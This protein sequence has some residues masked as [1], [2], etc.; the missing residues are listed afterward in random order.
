MATLLQCFPMSGNNRNL[1]WEGCH[2]VRD[3]GGLATEDGRQT[4]WGS[5][6]RADLLG[7]LTAQGRQQLLDYGVHTI[8]D[9]RSAEEAAKDPSAV[10][11]AEDGAPAYVR[12]QM[13]EARPQVRA[14]M[15]QVE[16][17]V[18]IYNIALDHY[19]DS[20]AAVMRAIAGAEPG[21]LVFHCHSGKDRTGMIAALL[22]SLAGVE[23][24]AIAA[25]FA[26][27]RERLWPQY[28]K[29]LD[30]AGGKEDVSRWYISNTE[31]QTMLDMLA[32][33]RDKYG[34]TEAYLLQAGQ[35][36]EE[37]HRLRSRLIE[38]KP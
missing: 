19:Q 34:G 14:L 12:V 1:E 11:A 16:T 31:P 4:A 22:L 36:A 27:T 2:N 25:D 6:L 15:K 9:L 23:E 5:L 32:H 18:E 3:L 20:N 13:D 17:R 8:I 7:R 29:W 30:D 28:Q 10:F 35:T 21:G 26:A 33:L 37:I 38:T 24:E